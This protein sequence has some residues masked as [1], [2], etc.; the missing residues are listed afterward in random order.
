[1][2][3]QPESKT[4]LSRNFLLRFA[5]CPQALQRPADLSLDR[6][7]DWITAIVLPRP[8]TQLGRPVQASRPTT[9]Q[10]SGGFGTP[11]SPQTLELPTESK[12]IL[13]EKPMDPPGMSDIRAS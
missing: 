13:L 8:R 2:V 3:D 7:E 11:T 5:Q 12:S 6:K 10:A 4:G 9:R 1:M